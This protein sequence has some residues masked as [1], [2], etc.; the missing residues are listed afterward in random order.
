MHDDNHV[1]VHRHNN[2]K[3]NDEVK[4]LNDHHGNHNQKSNDVDRD[5]L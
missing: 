3:N 4:A 2:Y 5:D 1:N